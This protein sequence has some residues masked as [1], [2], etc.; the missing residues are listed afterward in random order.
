LNLRQFWRF[1]LPTFTPVTTPTILSGIVAGRCYENRPAVE[2]TDTRV[3]SGQHVRRAFYAPCA[4]RQIDQAQ[5]A[6]Q[7]HTPSARSTP[8]PR[9]YGPRRSGARSISSVPGAIPREP[10]TS[11]MPRRTPCTPDASRDRASKR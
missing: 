6:R 3:S 2:H 5:Q 1:F 7:S 4:V 9:A 8:T 10:S 11:T